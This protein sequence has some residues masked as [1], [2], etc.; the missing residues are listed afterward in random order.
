MAGVEHLI[1]TNETTI[2]ADCIRDVCGDLRALGMKATDRDEWLLGFCI[3]RVDEQIR[4]ACN[5]DA[6]PEGLRMCAAGLILAEFLTEKRSMGDLDE[7]ALAIEPLLKQLAEGDT[8][9]VYATDKMTSQDQLFDK[10]LSLLRD[11]KQQFVRY[12]RLTW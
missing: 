11:R 10:L 2:S 4:N 5:L 6:V 3:R 12:R 9:I 8:N 7:T 1:E